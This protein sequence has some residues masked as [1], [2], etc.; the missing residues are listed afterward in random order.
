MDVARFIESLEVR[1][2]RLAPEGDP[3]VLRGPKGELISAIIELVA[4]HKPELLAYLQQRVVPVPPQADALEHL[5]RIAALGH[6]HRAGARLRENLRGEK[7]AVVAPRAADD[8]LLREALAV[9]GMRH[10]PSGHP[11]AHEDR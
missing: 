6:L 9:L 8:A 7:L 1:G 5:Q 11:E 4:A 10:Q 3:I 2:L